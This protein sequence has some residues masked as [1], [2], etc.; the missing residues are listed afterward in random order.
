MF[1]CCEHISSSLNNQS[2]EERERSHPFL[3]E[4][5][6]LNG[7]RRN[8]PPGGP[9]PNRPRPGWP[10]LFGLCSRLPA[11]A[12]V[13]RPSDLHRPSVHPQA[14]QQQPRQTEQR[15]E[16]AK[17]SSG[18]QDRQRRAQRLT[19]GEKPESGAPEPTDRPPH[20]SAALVARPSH[21][22]KRITAVVPP[23]SRSAGSASSS[24]CL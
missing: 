4:L 18:G 9:P 17:R 5:H 12:E 23:T 22:T 20:P 14:R 15:A 7:F 2:Q 10:P 13:R 6:Q 3:G 21:W 1:L 11:G 19:G 24:S 16:T 8:S